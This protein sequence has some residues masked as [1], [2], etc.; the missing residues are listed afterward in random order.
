VDKAGFTPMQALTAATRNGGLSVREDADFGTIEAGKLANLVFTAK[1]PS[2][3]IKALRTIVTTVKRGKAYPRA[4]FDPT[5]F[6]GKLY[7]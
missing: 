6:R 1:D 3:D 4:D 7:P 5:P 2:H